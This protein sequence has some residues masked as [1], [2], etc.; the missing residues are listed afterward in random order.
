[1]TEEQKESVVEW[2]EANPC[3]YNKGESISLVSFYY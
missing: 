1:L 3:M 2:V